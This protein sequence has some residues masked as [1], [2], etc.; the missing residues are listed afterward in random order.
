MADILTKQDGP[1]LN[2]TFNQ[3]DRGNA[4]SDEMVAE[5]TGIIE[6]A[7]KTS[8]IVV[9]RGAGKDFCVGR[10]VM[11]A[12]PK[13]DPDALRAPRFQRCG[14]QLL[15]RDAQRADPDHRRGAGPRARLRL[16]DRGRLR[17]HAR[18]RQGGLS[19]AG[20][21]AQHP[22]DHGD[23]VVRRPRAAQGDELSGLFEGRDHAGRALSFGIVSDVVPAAK[24][25]AAVE[26]CA[27]RS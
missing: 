5:L 6:G 15:R 4:V 24:L 1:I 25:D 27:P 11:G 21:G 3:P 8:S 18:Q 19:G 22:A 12:T 16:R 20:N 17:H 23:V 14:V 9:L 13:Q 7:D 10:A 26:A 2:I